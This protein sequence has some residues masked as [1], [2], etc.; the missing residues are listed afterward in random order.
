MTVPATTTGQSHKIRFVIQLSRPSFSLLVPPEPALV[1]RGC[2]EDP[3][4]SYLG[5]AGLEDD[6]DA[7]KCY[8]AQ[9]GPDVSEIAANYREVGQIA[10]A[11]LDAIHIGQSGSWQAGRFDNVGGKLPEIDTGERTDPDL[12][13]WHGDGLCRECTL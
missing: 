1:V 12:T 11:V 7:L 6:D 5:I 3:A 10:A 8:A 2:A 13:P 4:Y 9:S